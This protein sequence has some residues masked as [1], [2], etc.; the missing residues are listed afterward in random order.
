[1]SVKASAVG[2]GMRSYT[3]NIPRKNRVDWVGTLL[4]RFVF[5]CNKMPRFDDADEPATQYAPR[6]YRRV[7]DDQEIQGILTQ[8]TRDMR[9]RGAEIVD[10]IRIP[11][12]LELFSVGQAKSPPKTGA[13]R[14]PAAR[15]AQNATKMPAPMTKMRLAS[16]LPRTSRKA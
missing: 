7:H 11:H 4:T 8:A 1:M 14:R 5:A 9:G 15:K 2:V 10:P 3:V 16:H 13:A 12:M 6:R